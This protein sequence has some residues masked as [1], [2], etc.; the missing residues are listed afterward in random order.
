MLKR[1]WSPKKRREMS[2][3]SSSTC[4]DR[5]KW[6]PQTCPA[7]TGLEKGKW[8]NPSLSN[9]SSSVKDA[10]QRKWIGEHVPVGFIPYRYSSLHRFSEEKGHILIVLWHISAIPDISSNVN[11]KEDQGIFYSRQVKTNEKF[12]RIIISSSFRTGWGI[13][14][15]F[16]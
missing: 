9:P 11:K 1:K 10:A 2:L 12:G 16:S 15:Y 5:V 4:K 6:W 14:T 8:W 13:E 7:I 3:L